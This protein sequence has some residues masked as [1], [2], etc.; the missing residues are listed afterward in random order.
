MAGTEA[1]TDEEIK[2]LTAKTTAQN[3]YNNAMFDRGC[4]LIL[5]IMVGLTIVGIF[6]MTMIAFYNTFNNINPD[7]IVG[8]VEKTMKIT[9]AIA[10]QLNIVI[11]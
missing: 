7:H 11:T 5:L 2:R 4:I 6:S 10:R 1:A 9:E 3:N 8:D